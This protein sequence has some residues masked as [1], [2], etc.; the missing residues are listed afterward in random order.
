MEV[1]VRSK[2]GQSAHNSLVRKI[3]K[4]YKGKGYDVDADVSRYRRPGTIGGV[5]PDLIAKK[6]G[7][8]TVV[9][10]ETQE[11]VDSKRDQKQQHAFKKWS[12]DNPTK[13][14]KRVVTED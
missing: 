10:V 2:K 1:M 7:H 5:R 6:G 11:S 4:E 9:E 12:Q 8:Q 13:H 14:Y 3:A